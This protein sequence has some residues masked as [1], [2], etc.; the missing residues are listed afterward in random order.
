MGDEQA[1]ETQVLLWLRVE[2]NNEFIRRK[3]KT[4]FLC[5]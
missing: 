1:K 4:R 2:G 5:V 3:K